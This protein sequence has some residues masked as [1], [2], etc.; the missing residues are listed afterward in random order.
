MEAH[1][2][3]EQYFLAIGTARLLG[4]DLKQNFK[5]PYL[6]KN[7][8]EFWRR[9]HISL[10][11][12]FRDYVYIPLGGSRKSKPRVILNIF[13]VFLLSGL[14]HGANWTFV[15]WGFI[16]ALFYIP[17][18]FFKTERQTLTSHNH[19]PNIKTIL[20]IG[21]TFFIVV[22]AWVFFRAETIMH[23]FSYLERVF[24]SSLFTMPQVSK[25]MIVLLFLYM[26]VEWFQRQRNHLLDISFI[27]SKAM[28]Y[29]LYY[30]IVAVIF[31]FGGDTKPFI[32]FQF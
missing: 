22:I 30:S 7:L 18:L 3:L 20:Q 10:S 16:H 21:F 24:S 27:K 29:A 1:S 19:I 13:I 5:F 28:R 11:T 23:A 31:Y 14:W 12:W 17:I 32:Y 6:A 2:F 25:T 26:L 8:S 9:W 15:L 4:F